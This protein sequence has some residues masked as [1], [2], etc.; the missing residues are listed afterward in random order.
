[1]MMKSMES[2]CIVYCIHCCLDARGTG[3]NEEIRLIYSP[4]KMEL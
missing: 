4:N 3:K 1:M 2:Y